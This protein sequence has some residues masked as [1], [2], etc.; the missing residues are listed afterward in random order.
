MPTKKQRR[1]QQK[2][3]RHAYEYVYVDDEGNEVPVADE[4]DDEPR[5]R[6]KPGKKQPAAKRPAPRA[7][8]TVQPP[9]WRRVLKRGLIFA[10]L[11]YITVTIVSRDFT[12]AQRLQQTVFLLLVFLPFSYVMDSVTYRIWKRRVEGDAPEARR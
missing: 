1:R 4:D 11:M 8:R 12:T 9:S 3:R 2:G 5:E 10:P 6:G 7:G